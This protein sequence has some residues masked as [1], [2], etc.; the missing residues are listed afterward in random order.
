[1]KLNT[2]PNPGEGRGEKYI[3]CAQY[4]ECMDLAA[5]NNWDAFHCEECLWE[6]AAAPSPESTPAPEKLCGACHKRQTITPHAHLCASCLS[7][8][9][10][11]PKAR[12]KAHKRTKQTSA[13][14]RKTKEPA[15]EE[16]K[17][18]KEPAAQKAAVT[19]QFGKYGTVLKEVEQLAEE[20]MRPVD[21]QVVYILR[22]YLEKHRQQASTH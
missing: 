12:R 4:R 21:L 13:P 7:K 17:A 2:K 3:E 6:R 22:H 16:P 20:E 18:Q 14:I 19:I 11:R 8:L 5:R 15:H 1:M 10:P 9:N